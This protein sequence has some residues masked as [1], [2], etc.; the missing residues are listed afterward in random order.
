MRITRIETLDI[1]VPLGGLHS[2]AV[3]LTDSWGFATVLIYTD[4][5]LVGTGYTGVARGA[6]SELILA[7]VRDHYGPLVLGKDPANI[8]SLHRDL[9]WSP[10]H[11]VGRAGVTQ[12]AL[13]A[14]DI[15]LWDL[16]AQVAQKPL[17]DLLGGTSK[18]RMPAYNTNGGWLSFTEAELADNARETVD[19]G[20]SGVKIK[21]GKPD[22]RED[23]RRVQ[24]T[25]RALG[26]SVDLMVDVNQAWSLEHARRYGSQLA[27]LEVKWLE[28]PMDPDDWDA[29]RRLAR[30]IDTPIALGEHLY[31]ARDFR[32]FADADAVTYLQPDCT[33]VA[34]ITEFLVIA[35]IAASAN[36]PVCPHAGEMMQVHQ[37]LVFSAPTAHVFEHIPWGRELFAN[38]AKLDGGELLRPTEP[39]AG[40]R[41][42]PEVVERFLVS[43]VAAVE[44]GQLA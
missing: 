2:D 32:T 37:H 19:A 9:Y 42:I 21:L 10:V 4:T 7:T 20:F 22:G 17:C 6:G 31:S 16:A 24:V 15:A 13:A 8:R 29:H 39:G 38:P 34:G 26:G 35:E 1:R 30:V 40:T 28:E 5:G 44:E 18:T 14:V 23:L 25:R 12:M 3:N 41:M 33:R 36:L 43:P 27:D 11:W